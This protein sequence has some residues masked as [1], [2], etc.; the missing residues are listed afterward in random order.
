MN[1]LH[2][3]GP[4]TILLVDDD[5]LIHAI[6]KDVLGQAGHRIH[7]AVNGAEALELAAAIQPDVIL[8]DLVMPVLDGIA[9]TRELR[10]NEATRFTPII[11]ISSANDTNSR[12][13]AIEAGIDDFLSKPI[14]KSELLARV[15]SSLKIKRYHDHMQRYQQQ[16]ELDVA[17]RTNQLRASLTDIKHMSTEIVMR[18]CRAAESKDEVTG[19]HIH[20]MSHY[21]HAIARAMGCGQDI[22]NNILYTAPMHD[23]G[24]IGIPDQI[25]TKPGPLTQD[26]WKVMRR[27][28]TIGAHILEGSNL[29]FINLAEQIALTHHERWDGGGY[30]HGLMGEEI[31]LPGRIVAVADVFDAMTSPRLYR[32]SPY[33]VNYTIDYITNARGKHFD[34]DVVDAFLSI[35]QQ[36][37][38]IRD[39]AVAKLKLG[40]RHCPGPRSD[41]KSSAPS[42]GEP[43]DK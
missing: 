5:R 8:M 13:R 37:L 32:P 7:S 40:N 39:E 42:N 28:S 11:M 4:S 1:N 3:H 17:E 20:R 2:E 6:I 29:N 33:S 26:E 36:I 9:A 23:V 22:A 35:Q 19:L 12:V 30:P 27:H 10:A 25:L 14:E 34:P 31:P 16:L 15:A 21:S 38:M 18:L 43:P 41:T 24:K